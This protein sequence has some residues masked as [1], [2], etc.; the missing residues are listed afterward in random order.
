MA[1]YLHPI[2]ASEKVLDTTTGHIALRP[3]DAEWISAADAFAWVAFDG[4]LTAQ[5]V[6]AAEKAFQDDYPE[7]Y[8]NIL[9]TVYPP[10]RQRPR[11]FIREMLRRRYLRLRDEPPADRKQAIRDLLC[12]MPGRARQLDNQRVARG[13][14]RDKLVAALPGGSLRA[15]R[16]DRSWDKSS[17]TAISAS[18]F[19]LGVAINLAGYLEVG[20]I[21]M[22]RYAE[23]RKEQLLD[24]QRRKLRSDEQSSEVWFKT[25]ELRAWRD[26]SAAGETISSPVT[27]RASDPGVGLQDKAPSPGTSAPAKPPFDPVK[28][29]ALLIA[30][31]AGRR[32]TVKAARAFLV[33][34]FSSVPRP[35]AMRALMNDLND[36]WG[37]A[38]R[39]KPPANKH[40]KDPM[41]SEV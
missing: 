11:K 10:T 27:S 29:A 36:Q 37:P 15:Y 7:G 40:T 20:D 2:Q 28:A 12:D 19:G 14:A 41:I 24:H 25:A 3:W 34:H 22:E 18:L 26:G 5:Q 17:M 8:L 33:T 21:P 39:G 6:T 1:Q 13:A 32:P 38:K 9:T 30:N 16:R 35:T 23:L 4:V 31:Y